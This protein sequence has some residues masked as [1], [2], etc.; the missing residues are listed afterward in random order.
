MQRL[1]ALPRLDLHGVRHSD[2]PQELD[3]FLVEHMGA[4]SVTIIV[5]ASQY[6][7]L[8]VVEYLDKVGVAYTGGYPTTTIQ[9]QC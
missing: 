3:H 4:G 2:V 7:S 9:V 8:L 5:G 6:M 1:S